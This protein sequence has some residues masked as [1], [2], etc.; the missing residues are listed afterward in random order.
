M[1]MR[2]L[3]A[4]SQGALCTCLFAIGFVPWLL[5]SSLFGQGPIF[6]RDLPEGKRIFAD[7]NIAVSTAHCAPFLV[8]LIHLLAV[9]SAV[10]L[11]LDNHLAIQ[12]ELAHLKIGRSTF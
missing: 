7:I 12:A 8:V 1:L 6:L 3:D 2:V 10:L 11:L 4:L 9:L 5:V